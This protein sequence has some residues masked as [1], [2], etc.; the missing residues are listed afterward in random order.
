MS[1]KKVPP[2]K[3]VWLEAVTDWLAGLDD[4]G[5]P[6]LPLPSLAVSRSA[7]NQVVLMVLR[8]TTSATNV[9][10]VS[11]RWVERMTGV[12]HGTAAKALTDL[13]L[14]GWLYWTQRREN[15]VK[16]YHITI[17]G[18]EDVSA[19]A[20]AATSSSAETSAE[21]S[22]EN[23]SHT[24]DTPGTPLEDLTEEKQGPVC[25]SCGAVGRHDPD[26]TYRPFEDA[27]MSGEQLLAVELGA[28]VV[29]CA[30][31][32]QPGDLVK[33]PQDRN[34]WMHP[35]CVEKGRLAAYAHFA[36]PEDARRAREF[37]DQYRKENQS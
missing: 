29:L 5:R 18:G 27:S 9:A 37:P 23:V 26:C 36:H 20:S 19:P 31:C 3:L 24:P 8:A 28:E 6:T 30:E 10:M 7:M 35:E 12:N 14:F 16:L 13:E 15:R 4:E 33:F 1:R 2:F 25:R 21:T 32:H 22:A 17:P 34:R 11:A